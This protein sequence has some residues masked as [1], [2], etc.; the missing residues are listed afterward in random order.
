MLT[1]WIEIRTGLSKGSRVAAMAVL[2]ALMVGC[3][4]TGKVQEELAEQMMLGNYPGALL[5]VEDQKSGA[6]DGKN[7]LLYFLERGMLLHYDRQ[8]AES[9]I[10]FEEAKRIGDALYTESL[11]D[12]G[13]SLMSNDYALAYAGENFERTLIH[14]FSALNYIQLGEPDS[15]LVEVRQVGDYLR[16]LQVDSTNENVYQEDAFARYLSALLYESGGELDSAFVDYKKAASAY[17]AYGSKYSVAV[18]TSLMPNAE[19]VA[20]RLGEWAL[21]DLHEL[22]SGV[23]PYLHAERVAARLGEWA[24]DDLHEL[25]GGVPP[26]LLPPGTGE[27]IVLHYN[28]L[29]PIKGQEKYTI[30][31]SQ[32]WL[33]V[34][35]FQA[36]AD[37]GDREDV[38]RAIAFASQ[39]A[40]VDSVSVAFPKYVDRPYEIVHMMPR[41]SGA[42][43]ISAPE[44]V[45]DI[46]AIAVK[47]LADRI[48]RIRTKAIARA[49]VKYSIQKGAEMA[50]R[51]V[52][53]D[54]GNLLAAAT[55]L[56]GNI[57]RYASEQADKRV[58]STLPDQIW[59]SSI[60]LPE[61]AHDLTI[62]FV[63]AEQ[64]VVESHS[65]PEIQV[66][67]GSRQ[68]ITVRTVK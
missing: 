63:N 38:N 16:K 34:G 52:G 45:E 10:A 65:F 44:L 28:G 33:L 12:Q 58:W 30:P 32:A 31:F 21:D 13:F 29:S 57:A 23:P 53:G 51:Q 37:T 11:S 49:A 56:A 6:Y 39:I 19:R 20:A 68:F 15:A 25:D 2:A 1:G 4:S 42:L 22:D 3:A 36:A 61:G 46:G 62:D 67:A 14:L 41:A 18:P 60:V 17:R 8:F 55:A 50:A 35:A 43:E 40:G 26:Y 5:V 7:R 66:S 64:V 54:Y 9:N 48:V 47:D 27:V 24:L 59:M